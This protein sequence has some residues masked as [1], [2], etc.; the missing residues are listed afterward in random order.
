MKKILLL[1]LTI[2][3]LFSCSNSSAPKDKETSNVPTNVSNLE[4]NSIIDFQKAKLLVTGISIASETPINKVK[5]KA[6]TNHF[7]LINLKIKEINKDTQLSTVQFLLKD[8]TNKQYE[9]PGSWG[10]IDIGGG[11]SNF[12]ASEGATSFLANVNDEINLIFEVPENLQPQNTILQYN[13]K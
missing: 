1:Q 10:K 3:L 4:I 11:V 8:F 13:W 9:A 12:E 2:V 6:K 7:I 5:P